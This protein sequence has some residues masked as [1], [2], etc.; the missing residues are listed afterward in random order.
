MTLGCGQG[1]NPPSAVFSVRSIFPASGS[2]DGAI[3][4]TIGG[5]GFRSPATL[6]LGG[7]SANVTAITGT[8]ITAT[9]PRHDAGPVDVVV[10]NPGGESG[11]L[12]QGFT[13]VQAIPVDAPLVEGSVGDTTQRGIAGARVEVL[14]GP[15]AGTTTMTNPIGGF[16]FRVSADDTTRFRASKDGYVPAEGTLKP[17]CPT[18]ST[19]RI[20][21]VLQ[22]AGPS[23]DLTGDYTFS[24]MADSACTSLP[25][26]ARVR[27]YPT[28]IAPAPPSSTATFIAT[29][30]GSSFWTLD[31]PPF[32]IDHA[33]FRI[34]T[35]GTSVV[36]DFGIDEYFPD[37]VEEIGANTYIAFQGVSIVSVNPPVSIIS[38]P[39]DGTIEYC[40]ARSP[41]GK[42]YDCSPGKAV[43]S[44]QCTST[45]HRLILTR[46]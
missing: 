30:T 8:S 15:Q 28:T 22:S 14:D 42:D 36:F 25:A 23:L 19:R 11:R 6:T 12:T 31:G 4:V 44:A 41:M 24:L 10:T 13:Y 37:T 43:A 17:R 39:F 26:E 32:Y 27:T 33:A 21:F 18:C 5:T 20:D 1:P 2:I 3:S 9:I 7:L 29:I 38:V 40:E 16:S 34:L 46:R 35:A 45:A